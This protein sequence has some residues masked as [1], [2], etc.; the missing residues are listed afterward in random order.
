MQYVQELNLSSSTRKLIKQN[1]KP[2]L[3]N[4]KQDLDKYGWKANP[5]VWVIEFERVQ[6]K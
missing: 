1:A 4:K 3:F 2:I 5:Y 6:F